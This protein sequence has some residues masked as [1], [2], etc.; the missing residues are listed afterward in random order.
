MTPKSGPKPSRIIHARA[1]IRVNDIGAWTDTWFAGRGRVLNVAVEPGV[2]VQIEVFERRGRR[3]DRVIIHAENFQDTFRMD[4]DEPQ[5][6][7]HGLLQFAVGSLPPEPGLNLAISLFSPIPAGISTG[8]SASVCVG[9]LG[10]L[11]A[12]RPRKLGW[13]GL[14]RL[15]HRVETDKLGQQ[16]GIQD[17]IAAAHGGISDI[18]MDHYPDARVTAVR[19]AP[20]VRLELVRRLCLVYMG[21]PHRSSSMHEKVIAKLETGGRKRDILRRLTDLAGEAREALAGGDLESYGR[22][23]VRNNECQR[24]LHGELISPGAD[25]VA[26][27]ARRC[28]ALGWKVNGAGGRGGSMSVLAPA[29]DVLRRRMIAGIE[30]LGGGIRIL[31][32][33]LS[34]DGVTAWE[35]RG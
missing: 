19:L 17:Q 27:A 29:D 15:A 30:A 7:P 18:E 3:K 28:G 6:E 35:F 21:R 23:M 13:D 11:N 26:A 31:P 9:L 16:S 8:T 25:A 5:R 4:P 24:A 10:A 34:P 20:R 12:L 22:A 1:P 2:E 33:V 32:V 14:A